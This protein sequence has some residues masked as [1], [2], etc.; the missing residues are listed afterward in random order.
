M[1]DSSTTDPSTTTAV[2]EP[3]EPPPAATTPPEPPPE[4]EGRQDAPDEPLGDAGVK[5]LQRERKAA[6]EATAEA[7]RLRAEADVTNARLAELEAAEMRRQ[8]AADKGLD[9]EQAAVLVGSTAEEMAE[10]ADKVVAAFGPAR[11]DPQRRPTERLRPGAV[12]SAEPAESAGSIADRILRV[13]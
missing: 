4:P 3:V 2:P 6:E 9:A 7:E 10:F 1:T 13:G 8:V 11:P 12:P 5:A